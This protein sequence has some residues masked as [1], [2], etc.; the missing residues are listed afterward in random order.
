MLAHAM[1]SNL[2][3]R[4]ALAAASLLL[5]TPALAQEAPPASTPPA[6]AAPAQA[7]PTITKP[8]EL[9]QQVEAQYPPDALAQGL[10]ASV[11]LIITIAEDGSV[12]DVQ[13]TELV[14]NGFDEAAQAAVRQ[15]KFSPA[16]VD[17]VPAPVQV[18][19][20]YHFTLTAPPPAEGAEAQAE[21]EA[22]KATLTGQ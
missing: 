5:A 8:P 10:T 1:S 7:Q 3:A 14:G 13:P 16:E 19:Y 12:A 20:V 6:E 9:V 21:V 11:R 22:P 18:E 2:K 4:S 15:F 17:G